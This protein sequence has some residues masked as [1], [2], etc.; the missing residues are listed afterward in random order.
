[1]VSS[2]ASSDM[3]MNSGGTLLSSIG[4]VVGNTLSGENLLI[5]K[6]HERNE[7]A[8]HYIKQLVSANFKGFELLGRIGYNGRLHVVFPGSELTSLKPDDI[9]D[10]INQSIDPAMDYSSSDFTFQVEN[11]IEK[12]NNPCRHK[13]NNGPSLSAICDNYY[14]AITKVVNSNMSLFQRDAD[15]R[16]YLIIA[17][18]VNIFDS[19]GK[20]VKSEDFESNECVLYLLKRNSDISSKLV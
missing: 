1:M 3:N 6:A 12:Y 20:R 18:P 17:R 13:E 8:K 14:S 11:L 2:F 7:L 19:D 16:M 15:P 5:V 4:S 10:V 9:V